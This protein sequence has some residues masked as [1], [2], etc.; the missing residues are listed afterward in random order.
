AADCVLAAEILEG[1][2]TIG[3]RVGE[4][5]SRMVV[6]V[7]KYVLPKIKLAVEFD[8]SY[9]QPGDNTKCT[10]RANY[11]FGKPVAD[12]EVRVEVRRDGT[13]LPPETIPVFRTRATGEAVR[14]LKLADLIR[15]RDPNANETKLSFRVTV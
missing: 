12:A 9:Y 11:F 13:A 4:T 6:S 1:H 7:S 10:I 5:E 2:Y 3:C 15:G 8:K 14:E